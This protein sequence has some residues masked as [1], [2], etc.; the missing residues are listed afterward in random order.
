VTGLDD[1]A[2]A[3]ELGKLAFDV[4]ARVLRVLMTGAASPAQEAELRHTLGNEL[5]SRIALA[6]A[7]AKARAAVTHL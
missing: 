1:V 5:L 6:K 3:L 2:H 4:G 7:D